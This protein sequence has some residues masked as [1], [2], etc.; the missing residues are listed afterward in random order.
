MKCILRNRNL[1]LSWLIVLCHCRIQI[2][3]TAV[4]VVHAK[5]QKFRITDRHGKFQIKSKLL[6]IVKATRQHY[7]FSVVT[8]SWFIHAQIQKSYQDWACVRGMMLGIGF[9]HD[10]LSRVPVTWW[11]CINTIIYRNLVNKAK[12]LQNFS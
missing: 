5:C 11:N 1:K 9:V 4:Q 10:F 2:S 8:D 12:F 3:I 6:S 7:I